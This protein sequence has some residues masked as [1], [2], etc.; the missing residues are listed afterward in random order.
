LVFGV[1]TISNDNLQDLKTG[2]LVAATPWRQ[3]V[4]LIFGVIFGAL[5]I[6]PV[7]NL[8]NS[9]FGFQGAPGAGDAALAAPQA[10]LISTIAQGVL[11]GNLA[12]DLI[13]LGALIGAVVIA[14]DELLRHSGRGSLPALAVGMGIY[15]PFAV[16]GL[17]IVGTVLGHFYNRWAARQSNAGAAER[18][19]VLAATG[20]IVGDSLFNVV[21]AGLV[22]GSDDP[23]VLAV[24]EPGAWQMPVGVLVFAGIIYA[25]YA[26][27][28]KRA[29]EPLP[30][31]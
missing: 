21:F 12:W 13:G 31:A 14:M 28:G 20:L 6:P 23:E 4:S 2:Q 5:V 9:T 17:I 7:L 11:G 22:A 8:L 30:E 1:A 24:L 16:T 10:A 19:G 26:W 25:L 27:T 3:Q 29:V 15:L 18:L